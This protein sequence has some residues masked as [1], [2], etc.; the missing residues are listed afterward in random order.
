MPACPGNWAGGGGY[1]T[2]GKEGGGIQV[3]TN[4]SHFPLIRYDKVHSPPNTASS[5]LGLGGRQE[6]KKYMAPSDAGLR[7]GADRS[8]L[9][10]RSQVPGEAGPSTELEPGALGF[11]AQLRL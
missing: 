8:W 11:W 6:S 4:C 3:G 1:L 10:G 2:R 7:P 9:V 5:G